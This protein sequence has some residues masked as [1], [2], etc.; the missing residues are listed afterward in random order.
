MTTQGEP[1][2]EL[3]FD[4]IIPKLTLLYHFTLIWK[5]NMQIHQVYLYI[6]ECDRAYA[7]CMGKTQ[8]KANETCNV[9]ALIVLSSKN[10]YRV[11]YRPYIFCCRGHCNICLLC[12]FQ[13]SIYF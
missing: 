2:T 1:L 10:F 12:Y 9:R 13:T 4:Q 5:Q 7:T 8:R 11:E 3:H 6:V